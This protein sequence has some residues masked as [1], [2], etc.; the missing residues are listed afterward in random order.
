MQRL[1]NRSFAVFTLA[2]TLLFAWILQPFFGAILWGVVAAILFAPVN[3]RLLRRWPRRRNL[4]TGATLLL[5]VALVIV[6]TM[7]LGMALLR[8]AT[9]VYTQIRSGEIDF[10]HYFL[11][12]QAALPQWAHIALER[13]G[14]TDYDAIRSRLNS[15][16]ASSFQ[17]LAAHAF[18][19]GQSTLSFFLSLGVMLYLTF[20]LLRDGK[21]LAARLETMVP[22]AAD[23]RQ[24]ILE[25]FVTV[26]QA[27]IK[28]SII[29]AIVQGII[30]GVVFWAL[31]VH[32]ALLWGVSMGLFS[33]LPAIGTGLV[34]VPVALYLLLTGAV[35]KGAVLVFCG[36]FVIGMVDNVLRPILVG[37]DTRLPDYVVLI[38]TL[39]G[40]E[41]FGFN[42][43]IIGPV[44]AALFIAVWQ[45]LAKEG[46]KPAAALND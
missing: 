41:V 23:R 30:G 22:L 27:T 2:V 39:G 46:E 37:R 11:Q 6:P 36:L 26:V 3:E 5:I 29:V 14:L 20:F 4:A 44:V 40:L 1:Q 38:S 12:V 43:F 35:W 19:F 45:I 28:G 24:A 32:A 17:L 8:E 18:N 31:G 33:L 9:W 25:K 21:A 16:L 7:V 13:F 42:G 10:G 15:G 34:W